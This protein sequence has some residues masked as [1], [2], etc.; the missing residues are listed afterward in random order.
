MK[1]FLFT[2]AALLMAGSL[3]AQECYL[4]VDD[5]EVSQELLA[6][7]SAKK[8]RVTVSV[9]ADFS[10]YVSA[11][12]IRWTLPEHVSLYA[13]ATGTTYDLTYMDK[14][15]QDITFTPGLSVDYDHQTAIAAVLL[16]QGYY[17]EEGMD[18]DEDD[19]VTYGN[20]KWLGQYE[21][22]LQMTLQ[23]DQ[24]FTGGDLILQTEPAS[25][26]DPRGPIVPKGQTIVKVCHITVE[27][28]QEPVVT[29]A[30]V[31][32]L[33][34]GD[35]AYIFDVE[36]PEGAELK[37]Y[38]DGVEVEIPYVVNRTDVDQIVK[39]TATSHIEG[40]TDGTVTGEYMVPALPVVVPEDLTGEIVIGEPTEDGVV[41]IEY[42]G[43]EDVTIV[44]TVNGEEV[45]VV[46]GTVTV[47]E[48]ESVIVVTVTAD[49]YND[50][51]GEK[52]V[53]YTE[54][55]PEQTAAPTYTIVDDHEAQTVTVTATGNG[56]I[57]ILWD[58]QLVAEGD[59]EAE[60]V[61]PY[62]DDPEGEEFGFTVYAQEEGKLISEPVNGE[63]VVPGKPA[64]PVEPEQTAMPEITYV[65][66][67]TEVI[68]SAT[69]EG[70][71][72]LMVDG[73]VV[74]N[75]VTIVRGD[76]DVTIVVTAT[77]QA[78][79]QLVSEV[80]TEEI[81]IPAYVD[82]PEGHMTGYWLVLIDKDGNEVWENLDNTNPNDP[83]QHQTNVAL[84][85][86]QFGGQPLSATM[87][88]DDNPMVPFYFMIDGVRYAC[89]G[90]DV[91]PDY[92]Y[93][94]NNPLFESENFWNV[95]VGYYYTIGVLAD[96]ETGNLYMQIS[97]G[98]YTGIDEMNADKAV[99][100]V[101]YFNMAGQEMQEANG[102]TIVVTTYTDGTTSAVKVMK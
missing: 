54:P 30:P 23:F 87:T 51:T 86:S 82:D 65:V 24:E 53:T 99:A 40:Q 43:D 74:D 100:G 88:D 19:P 67:D 37:L 18:P 94:N 47:G 14:M 22:Y 83:D 48:G 45:E 16:E 72:I 68:I 33:T 39:L 62:G 84:H 15:E 1:K 78:D 3:F 90:E 46:D 71:V 58:E 55:V 102:M 60:W 12:Q 101:R 80:A 26:D 63:V 8:R 9:K 31:I 50:L 75:P 59:G 41:T 57:T 49:G 29:D 10:A 52:T 89:E 79:G 70:E 56:H 44:V 32:I 93:A 77:A 4:Y 13:L 73:E 64:T 6:Q 25:T 7:T 95:N 42:T 35:N 92:G 69:G 28:P 5:F 2:L 66:T 17:Y 85:Y 61:I 20:P 21:D 27:G 11:W 76:E 36:G 34:A 38:V 96:P 97:K 91:V 98:L 81:V